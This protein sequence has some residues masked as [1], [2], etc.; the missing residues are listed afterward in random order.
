[1]KR[2]PTFCPFCTANHY[3]NLGNPSLKLDVEFASRS[4]TYLSGQVISHS[5][6]KRF[7]KL[8]QFLPK[9]LQHTQ[10]RMNK[11]RLSAVNFI[12]KS[13]SKSF[14]N[15]I[16]YN[17]VGFKC[18]C[19]T[20]SRQYI[21]L[22]YKF[23]PEELNLDGHWEVAISEISYPSM[24]QNV[25]ERK[26]RFFDK[27]FSKSSEFYC[28]ESGLNPSITDTVE[29]M[30][31]LIQERHNHSGNCIKVK[32]PRRT[33]KLEIYLEKD[34]SGLSCFSTDLG[35]LIRSNVGN[36]F[37]VMLRRK[38][39]QKPKFAYDIVRIHSLMIYTDLIEYKIVGDTKAPLLQCFLFFE[40][41]V[42]RHFNYWTVHELSD[43]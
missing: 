43:I 18:I 9:N 21:E 13:W 41:Q 25:T 22:F 16:V 40:A 33:Q 28:L 3:E 17:R 27:K 10:K 37:G 42:R 23:S 20:I 6:Q 29:S 26:L 31:I 12:G 2:I 34:G 35:H 30:N 8:L 19:A 14:N 15:G 38:G 1:M 32:E 7:S 4:M 5:E 11:M 36:E 24:Y 39:P